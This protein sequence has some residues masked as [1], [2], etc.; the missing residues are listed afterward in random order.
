MDVRHSQMIAKLSEH[1][2]RVAGRECEDLD[3]WADEIW[4]VRS[5]WAPQGFTVYLTWL[6]DPQWDDQRQPGQAVWAV[7][8]CLKRPAG[9]SEAEG[10]PLMSVKHWPGEVP[11]FLAGLATLRDK[12]RRTSH[13]T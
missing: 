2:W 6:V 8:T 10:S 13:C 1:G 9:R 3:R 4:A 5:E 7:G 12:H 11:E